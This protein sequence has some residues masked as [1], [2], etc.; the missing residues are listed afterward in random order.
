V[1]TRR[2]TVDLLTSQ[3]LAW[4]LLVPAS[5]EAVKIRTSRIVRRDSSANL[6]TG[7]GE[8]ADRTI[9]SGFQRFMRSRAPP[10]RLRHRSSCHASR[11]AQRSSRRR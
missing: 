11:G 1:I 9:S 7:P 10:I 5:L 8:P 4:G 2:N 6:G 3:R